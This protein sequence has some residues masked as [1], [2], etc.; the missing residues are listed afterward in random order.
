MQIYFFDV[1]IIQNLQFFSNSEN[2]KTSKNLDF[3]ISKNYC[4]GKL[5][6]F[7]SAYFHKFVSCFWFPIILE[8]GRDRKNF[9]PPHPLNRILAWVAGLSSSGTKM[10][11]DF[12]HPPL[13]SYLGGVGEWK[14][15]L[16]HLFLGNELCC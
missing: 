9:I 4:F 16:G 13:R 10:K 1:S 15:F 14:F 7:V 2:L 11:F 12:R 5:K 3:R 8:L 6:L